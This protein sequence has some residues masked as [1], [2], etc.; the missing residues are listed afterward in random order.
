MPAKP[1]VSVRHIHAEPADERTSSAAT[2]DITWLA[3]DETGAV[4]RH[5]PARALLRAV[6]RRDR[7]DAARAERQGRAAMFATIVT[8]HDTPPGFVSP[9][10]DDVNH[11]H[12]RVGA[13]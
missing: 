3:L 11:Q 1:P 6:Q 12:P 5:A 9:T 10:S 4:T 2:G 8:W 13:D 7:R